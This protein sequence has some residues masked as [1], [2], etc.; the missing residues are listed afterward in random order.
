MR[1]LL[2]YLTPGA[3]LIGAVGA[4]LGISHTLFRE[5]E[6]S[7]SLSW[8]VFTVTVAAM[9]GILS[10]F[11]AE[12]FR[13]AHAAQRIFIAHPHAQQQLAT[14]VA[15]GL[16][17]KGIR[18]WRA[19]ERVKPGENWREAIELALRDSDVLLAI[20]TPSSSSAIRS[21]IAAAQR[22]GVRVIPV[23]FRGTTLPPEVAD[24]SA[25]MISEADP[26]AAEWIVKAIA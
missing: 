5:L 18:V 3:S 14:E 15:D 2:K 1:R 10:K 8:V 25:V 9:V 20:L 11:I 19:D 23:A 26:H 4:F 7:R 12:W 17:R 16:R 24:V 22:H 13:Q 21:E 6:G